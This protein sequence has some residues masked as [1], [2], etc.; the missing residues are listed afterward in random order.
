MEVVLP[1]GG[2]FFPTHPG[3]QGSLCPIH[4]VSPQ[5][6]SKA[7]PRRPDSSAKGTPNHSSREAMGATSEVPLHYHKAVHFYSYP[8]RLHWHLYNCTSQSPCTMPNTSCVP[9]ERAPPVIWSC[10]QVPQPPGL[11]PV[12]SKHIRT[13]KL[14]QEITRAQLLCRMLCVGH[15][16]SPCNSL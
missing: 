12:C 4:L 14:H 1:P 5:P 16:I 7:L 6:S 10:E 15:L 9:N 11:A 3:L 8:A 2:W 13:V